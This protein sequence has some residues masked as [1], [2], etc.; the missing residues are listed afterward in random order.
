[1][2]SSLKFTTDNDASGSEKSVYCNLDP[3]EKTSSAM[4]LTLKVVM[5]QV[6]SI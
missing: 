2:Q 1:M 4:V 6:K 5:R 3:V